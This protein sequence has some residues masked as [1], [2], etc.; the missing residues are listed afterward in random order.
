MGKEDICGR[1]TFYKT[2]YQHS[3]GFGYAFEDN[4]VYKL[5]VSNLLPEYLNDTYFYPME[6]INDRISK[7]YFLELQ[8][9]EPYPDVKWE[10]KTLDIVDPDSRLRIFLS[11]EKV[12]SGIAALFFENCI[13]KKIV[14]PYI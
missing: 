6:N 7:K 11:V 2:T 5:T 10:S 14:P 9:K 4:I 12:A 1:R 8:N 13:T 3:G